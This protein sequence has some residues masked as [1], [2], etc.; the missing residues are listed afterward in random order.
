MLF[1]FIKHNLYITSNIDYKLL[2]VYFCSMHGY[3]ICMFLLYF[4]NLST[5]ISQCIPGVYV[6]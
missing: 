3:D 6:L 5:Q 1:L 4:D 2:N